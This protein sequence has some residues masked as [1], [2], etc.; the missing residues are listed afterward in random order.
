[1]LTFSVPSNVSQ[2]ANYKAP[3]PLSNVSLSHLSSPENDYEQLLELLLPSS[4]AV[5]ASLDPASVGECHRAGSCGDNKDGASFDDVQQ[6]SKTSLPPLSDSRVYENVQVPYHH[7]PAPVSAPY[8][9]VYTPHSSLQAML[10]RV[11][12]H[13]C[14]VTTRQARTA[15][16]LKR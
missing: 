9:T 11:D 2:N 16:R 6:R 7:Q 4:H 8:D 3:T 15:S 13:T 14:Y 10:R 12:P 1:M 5:N